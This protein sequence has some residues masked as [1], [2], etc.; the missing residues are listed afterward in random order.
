MLTIVIITIVIALLFDFLN[1]MNDAA[2]S[3][4]TIVATR[5]FSPTT[6]VLWAAFWNFA[7]IFIFGV[8]VAKTMGGGIVHQELMNEY[9]I[10]SA[11]I[12]SVLWVAIC[13]RFGLP[14]SVS[15]ALIGGMIGPAWFAHGSAALLF[16]GIFKIAIFIVL[17]PL[18]GLLLGFFMMCLTMLV[19]RRRHPMKVEGLFKG[20]QMLSSA[21]FSLG[22][23][24]NDAQKTMGII[25]VLLFSVAGKSAFVDEYLY[26]NGEFYIPT[27]LII[28]CYTVIALGTVVGGKKVMKTLGD[29]LAKLK[30]VQGFCAE[31]SGALTLIGTAVLG[32]PVSTTHT[33]TGSIIGTGITKGV[34]SVRWA[35]A[36]NIMAAWVFTIPATIA[37]SGIIY[38]IMTFFIPATA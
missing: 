21:I 38:W 23:G 17:S 32:V 20:M 15:H 4:A 2:N 16:S 13:T 37:M 19:F 24:A 35:T 1:G 27:W 5:V 12:G 18:I 14:I 10:L 33:I 9:L 31:T 28:T 36:T 34:A 26:A 6:A 22:H 25:A 30:P 3:I 29:G 8:H 11:L 7:A